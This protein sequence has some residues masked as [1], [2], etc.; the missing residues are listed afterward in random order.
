[1]T[2]SLSLPF[3]W[4]S[5]GTGVIPVVP[6][7]MH[8]STLNSVYMAQFTWFT[9]SSR[10]I[11]VI[12]CHSSSLLLRLSNVCILQDFSIQFLCPAVMRSE[13]EKILSTNACDAGAERSSRARGP[14]SLSVHSHLLQQEFNPIFDVQVSLRQLWYSWTCTV[15]WTGR[16]MEECFSIYFYFYLVCSFLSLCHYMYV[17]RPR[18]LVVRRLSKS[19]DL[20]WMES[21]KS[22]TTVLAGCAMTTTT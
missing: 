5:H 20:I 8:I 6:I 22:D 12:T 7:P 17:W 16:L 14:M 18:A 9:F 3:P 19:T 10:F 11:L 1:M 21:W 4:E 2:H 15:L 13:R